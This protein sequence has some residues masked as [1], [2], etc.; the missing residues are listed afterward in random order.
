MITSSEST[1]LIHHSKWDTRSQTLG[2][3]AHHQIHLLQKLH[4]T[5]GTHTFTRQLRD[6]LLGRLNFAADVVPLT[7]NFPRSLLPLLHWWAQSQ[8]LS[9]VAPWILPQPTLIIIT[10]DSDSGWG[11]QSSNS[12]QAQGLWSPTQ[13][14]LH[15]NARELLVPLLFL[16]KFPNVR[17]I[18]VRF[19]LDNQVAVHCI[20]HQSS[21][22]SLPFLSI[23]ED[24][25][26][27]TEYWNL[28][29]SSR[30]IVLVVTCL[31]CLFLGCCGAQCAQ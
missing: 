6:S 27:L 18:C 12:L 4:Q 11:L 29:L 14:Q 3:L 31:L 16:K 10:D 13:S 19:Q 2:M 23:S 22:R 17:D 8:W 26:F 28:C 24:L 15:I 20:S 7:R 1:T 25:L 9:S 30:H 5:L 21:S